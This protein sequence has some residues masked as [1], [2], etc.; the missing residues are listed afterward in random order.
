M[1]HQR[2]NECPCDGVNERLL[3]QDPSDLSISYLACDVP[4]TVWH[5]MHHMT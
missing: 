3:E 5:L 4:S 2:H 1:E